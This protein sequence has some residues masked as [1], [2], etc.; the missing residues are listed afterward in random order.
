[1]ARNQEQ[2]AETTQ[3]TE[4]P[5]TEGAATPAAAAAPAKSGDER[6]SKVTL[7]EA[8][9]KLYG[10]NTTAG[11]VVNRADLIRGLWTVNRMKRGEIKNEINRQLKA[12]GQKEIAYQIV[13]QATKGLVG[14][15]VEAQ[16]ATTAS[17]EAPAAEAPA[18]G[19]A[20]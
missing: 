15:P 16:A 3:A 1:M 10:N 14:G 18:E 11:Q 6:F 20:E 19:G 9:A 4:A 5:A 17:T 12:T 13:F 7:D 8:G 2:S